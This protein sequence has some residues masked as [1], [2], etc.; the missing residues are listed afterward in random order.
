[1]LELRDALT[2][3]TDLGF[4]RRTGLEQ[5]DLQDAFHRVLAQDV[6]SDIDLPPFPQATRDGFACRRADLHHPLEVVETIAAGSSPQRM[7]GANQCARIM[8]GAVM[9]AGADCVV[10]LEQVEHLADA[11]IRCL[12][13]GAERHIC[14]RGAHASAGQTLLR[15]GE[16][17]EAAH[18][19]VLAGVGCVRP[20]V[21]RRPA[22]GVI[23]TGSEL[24]EPACAPGPG[25]IRNSNSFQLSALVLGTSAVPR[26]YGVVV[27]DKEVMQDALQKGMDEND[28]V[29]LSGGIAQG[30]YDL[31]R[32]IFA[33]SHVEL[34]F[35]RIGPPPGRPVVLGVS[36]R[37]LCFGLSGNP[38]S[39]FVAFELIVKP[40]LYALA[41]HRFR[42]ATSR[43]E[44][45]APIEK[46]NIDK[47]LWLPVRVGDDGRM[48]PIACRR[49][50]GIAA[51]CG[52]NG[53]IHVP[54]GAP[55]PAPGESVV[56]RRI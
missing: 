10:M 35:D 8:T 53:L 17:I 46:R 22:V 51:L 27:D 34:L 2:L 24:V 7:V 15:A 4:H 18:V 55:G 45:A 26:N 43:G 32:S 54:A 41:G 36:D 48:H 16:M 38:I 3:V 12:S 33:E 19:A 29:V 30:D 47:D 11:R 5:V 28:A 20:L 6:V 39:N 40:A 56:A 44:L 49:W 21:S 13:A 9:P 42:P 31:V 23:A 50:A 52:A 14:P 37:A 1:M 25:Q